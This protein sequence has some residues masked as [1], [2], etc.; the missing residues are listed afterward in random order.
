MLIVGRHGATDLNQRQILQGTSDPPLTER[1]V[2]QAETLGNFLSRLKI[3]AMLC[4]DLRRARQT[5]EIC[6]RV[7]CPEFEIDSRLRERDFGEY[8]AL[9]QPELVTKR[10]DRGLSVLDPSQDWTGVN[11]VESDA[12]VAARTIEAL[13]IRSLLELFGEPDRHVVIV[14]HSGVIKSLTSMLCFESTTRHRSLR[15]NEGGLVR[16]RSEAP[17]TLTIDAALQNSD[18]ERIVG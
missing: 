18:L 13:E 2:R 15:I 9:A 8:E 14:C 1:G 3:E 10:E 5:A 7:G 6:R 12:D 4:S 17:G 16:F 11:E